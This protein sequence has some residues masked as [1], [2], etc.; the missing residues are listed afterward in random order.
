M[1]K[2]NKKLAKQ[3]FVIGAFIVLLSIIMVGCHSKNEVAGFNTY[4][5]NKNTPTELPKLERVERTIQ[6]GE[7]ISEVQAELAPD[8]SYGNLMPL[9]EQA[10]PDKNLHTFKE[11]ETFILFKQVGEKSN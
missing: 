9:I 3:Y 8:V 6:S 5:N 4:V 7:T 2:S 11:G 10:N 1:K